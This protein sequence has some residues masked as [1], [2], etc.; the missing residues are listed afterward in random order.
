M[1]TALFYHPVFLEHDTGLGHPE[2]KQRI[3]SVMQRIDSLD[4]LSSCELLEAPEI[5]EE[6]VKK[7]H[8]PVYVTQLKRY[9]EA[10]GGNID[11]DTAVSKASWEAAL[12]AAGAA[13]EAVSYSLAG[14]GPS[15][16]LVR[17]PGHHALSNKAMGFCLLNNAA[18]AV[19][20]AKDAGIKKIL[21]FDWDAHHGNGDQE[22]FERDPDV[23]YISTHQMPLFPGTGDIAETGIGSG[24]GSIINIPLHPGAGDNA[25]S[26][27]L[28]EIIEPVASQFKPDL[29]ILEAGFDSHHGDPL[30]NLQFSC[31]AFSHAA[32]RLSELTPNP[33]I[34]LL[35]GGYDTRA[36]PYC[37]E[38]T[39]AGM[40]GRPYIE[41]EFLGRTLEGSLSELDAN[42]EKLKAI[43]KRDGVFEL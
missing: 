40:S 22:F 19:A 32:A 2:S 9:C 3:E 28:E 26:K 43:I 20:L 39:I 1:K 42:I 41:P 16:C 4:Y 14:R 34:A 6:I 13:A 7:I 33:P 35:E 8:D 31:T 38:A 21:V 15:F 27:V 12:R 10:G 11:M 36:L 37:V 29:L 23:L 17:P 30:A 24:V 25:M 18:I 5:S